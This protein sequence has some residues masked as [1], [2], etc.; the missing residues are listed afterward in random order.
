M[1]LLALGVIERVLYMLPESVV[2]DG[3][4]LLD[5]GASD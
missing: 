2:G 1:S 3:G 4:W 5:T